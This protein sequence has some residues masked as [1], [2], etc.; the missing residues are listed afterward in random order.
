MLFLD[1][2]YPQFDL[3]VKK[4]YNNFMPITQSAKKALRQSKKR[5]LLNLEYTRK[6]KD[7]WQSK[8]LFRIYKAV[9]KAA[10]HGLI[11]KMK[12]AR[13]KAQAARFFRSLPKNQSAK[14]TQKTA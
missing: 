11:K 14:D 8:D 10:K 13:M 2:S 5:R 9:D 4:R 3:F 1:Q 12:A 7:A 6:I